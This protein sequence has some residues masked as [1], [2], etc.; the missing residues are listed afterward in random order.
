MLKSL[1]TMSNFIRAVISLVL[2]GGVGAG[3]WFGYQ[4]YFQNELTLKRKDD[5]LQASQAEVQRLNE[6]VAAKQLE[7]ERLDTAVRLLKVDH[8]LAHIEVLKQQETTPGDRSTLV[9]TFSFVEVDDQGRPLG[10]PRVHTVKGDILYVEAWVV[11][12]EDQYVER[13]D[14]FRGTSIC[15]F[16]RLWGEYQEPN[17]G[18][19]IEAVGSR[20]AAYSRGDEPSELE[21][22]IWE[23]FWDYATDPDKA[24][25]AGVRV[26]D[27][28]A[29]ANK[30]I[31]GRRY[32]VE[33][34]ASDG[35]SIKPE[36]APPGGG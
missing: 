2:V 26:A 32:R 29:T 8:R 10:E 17:D 11:K 13:A 19:K 6:D 34:R 25:E 31:P 14:P 30:L 24:R 27:V 9:T 16:R 18:Y 1:D 23:N 15:L 5:E 33:L 3:A 21:R 4:T 35:L 12:F 7:I 36:F 20:P 22:E 28:E